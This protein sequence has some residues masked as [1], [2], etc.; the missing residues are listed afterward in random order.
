[1]KSAIFWRNDLI[2]GTREKFD[3]DMKANLR[4]YAQDFEESYSG[5]D[6][7]E[8]INHYDTNKVPSFK[9]TL[10]LM[11]SLRNFSAQV[12]KYFMEKISV[13][14]YVGFILKQR[15]DAGMKVVKTNPK[16]QYIFWNNI[17]STYVGLSE[18][19]LEEFQKTQFGINLYEVTSN[20][21][22]L[23]LVSVY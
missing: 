1:M 6:I 18:R 16:K 12:D 5:L 21:E 8:F 9:E 10:S 14:K 11:T 20:E 4:K 2:H 7:N 17:I 23:E 19:D 3:S 13:E 15:L 22:L